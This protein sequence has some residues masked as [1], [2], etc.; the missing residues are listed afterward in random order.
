MTPALLNYQEFKQTN[1]FT[2][3]FG[4]YIC[5]PAKIKLLYCQWTR[6]VF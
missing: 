4:R 2:Q 1:L 5:S 3:T 6:T